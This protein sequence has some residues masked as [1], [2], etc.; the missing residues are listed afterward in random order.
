MLAIIIILGSLPALELI[1]LLFVLLSQPSVF[2]IWVWK[3]DFS[4]DMPTQI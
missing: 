1:C 3:S 2:L 4:C